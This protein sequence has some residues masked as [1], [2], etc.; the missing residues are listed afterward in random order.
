VLRLADN[1][2]GDHAGH[3]AT[4]CPRL[5]ELDLEGNQIG[6]PG[7]AELAR[8]AD[9]AALGLRDNHITDAG[10]RALGAHGPY[11]RLDLSKNRLTDYGCSD[12]LL[13][14]APP[15]PADC[16]LALHD[17]NGDLPRR[18][19]NAGMHAPA[20]AALRS[21]AVPSGQTDVPD[22]VPA[23][24]SSLI[25]PIEAAFDGVP[26]PDAHH[27]SLFDAEAADNYASYDGPHRHRGPWQSIPAAHLKACQW[28]IPHLDAQGIAYYLPA[29]VTADLKRRLWPDQWFDGWLF[30]SLQFSL[31]PGRG[32]HLRDYSR[33][34]LSV[35]DAPQRAAIAAYVQAVSDE[36]DARAAWAAVLRHDIS[37]DDGHWFDVWWP[38]ES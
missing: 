15:L 3:L 32:D 21:R 7:A 13:A 33:D 5:T 31:T 16:W 38:P 29:I 28:A 35:L 10:A 2:I 18:A 37:G 36:P 14:W 6:D 12:L 4:L 8:M 25:A 30:D 27:R 19:G 20:I 9:L 26:P 22:A 17:N 34:R 24:W 11:R 1:R 23:L